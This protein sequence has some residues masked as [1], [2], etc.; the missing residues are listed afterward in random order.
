MKHILTLFTAALLAAPLTT[1]QAAPPARPNILHFH[2]DDHRADGVRA[3][4]KGRIIY[5][6]VHLPAGAA[7]FRA[8]DFSSTSS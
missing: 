3:L 4:G 1:L 2:G 6:R 5:V 7:E 8:L